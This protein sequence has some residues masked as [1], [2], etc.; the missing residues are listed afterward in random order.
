[1]YYIINLITINPN[2][3]N[4]ILENGLINK[5]VKSNIL[6]FNFINPRLFLD[7]NDKNIND[8]IYGGGP[9]LL[10]KPEPLYKALYKA[11]N[12]CN[13]YY[14]I[15]LTPKGKILNLNIIKKLLTYKSLIFIC[16]RYS[17][18]DY[19]IIKKYVNLELSIGDYIVSCGEISSLVVIDS[20]IRYIP[21]IISNNS[22]LNDSFNFYNSLLSYPMYTKPFNFKGMKVPKVLLSGNHAKIE[23]WRYK[24]ALKNTYK[25]KLYL[26]KK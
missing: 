1:M 4:S 13:K 5:A 9:G 26:I 11:K 15:Y 17:G 2:F 24:K 25:K 7:I 19:R 6:K 21:G 20:F 23:R 8:K 22:N 10:I 3:F 12:I 18:I 16:G 14:I